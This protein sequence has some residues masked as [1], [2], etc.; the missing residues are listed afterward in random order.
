MNVPGHDGIAGARGHCFPKDLSALISRS[1]E[2]GIE[3]K[4]LQA[5]QNKNLEIVAPENRDWEKMV[6]RAVSKKNK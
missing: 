1:Q 5:L 4:L 2:V 3:P 6:G